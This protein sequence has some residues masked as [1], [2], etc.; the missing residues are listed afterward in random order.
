MWS[1]AALS[2]RQ[3]SDVKD[4]GG[5]EMTA[6]AMNRHKKNADV[7]AAG[8]GLLGCM[9]GSD[10]HGSGIR[11]T[12][13]A[14]EALAN[15][16][17]FATPEDDADA[18]AGDA[19]VASECS[20][21]ALFQL[22]TLSVRRDGSDGGR[23]WL[24]QLEEACKGGSSSGSITNGDESNDSLS[25]TVSK[26]MR[27]RESHPG[28]QTWALRLLWALSSIPKRTD[29][30]HAE[31]EKVEVEAQADDDADGFGRIDEGVVVA[32]G[33]VPALDATGELLDAVGAAVERHSNDAAV[34]STAL[35]L[36]LNLSAAAR[37]LDASS[38]KAA[39][40][41]TAN[42]IKAHPDSTEL[43][44]GGCAVICNLC[45][46]G[47]A[48]K[49]DDGDGAGG[50]D[51]AAAAVRSAFAAEGGVE[52]LVALLQRRSRDGK[53]DEG[54]LDLQAE[55]CAALTALCVD[56]AAS[57][58][59][60]AEAGG[61]RAL[62]GVYRDQI[63]R[64]VPEARILR[65]R[66]CETLASLAVSRAHVPTLNGSGIM[67]D[68]IKNALEEGS[69]SKP[70][71]A[72]ASASS[73]GAAANRRGSAKGVAVAIPLVMLN[74]LSANCSTEGE[75]AAKSATASTIVKFV[76]QN[77]STSAEAGAALSM[78]RALTATGGQDCV[79]VVVRSNVALD[80]I[81][82]AMETYGSDASLQEH[83]CALLSNIYCRSGG[84]LSHRDSSDIIS[85]GLEAEL[86]ARALRSHPCKEGVEERAC[87]A[88]RNFCAA[89]PL[90]VLS[91]DS[92]VP[93]LLS[94]AEEVARVLARTDSDGG[95]SGVS[96][97][98]RENAAG[99]LWALARVSLTICATVAS[100]SDSVVASISDSLHPFS[101]V[102]T[103][104]CDAVGALE[105]LSRI[106]DTHVDMGTAPRVDAVLECI[107]KY[108]GKED[109]VS[110]GVSILAALAVHTHQAKVN[111]IENELTIPRTI[112]CMYQY[113]D[114]ALI[115]GSA[116]AILASVAVDNYIKEQIV[117]EGGINLI[118]TVMSSYKSDEWVVEN[119]C[120]VLGNL[121]S[122][123]QSDIL[124]G[125]DIV[126]KIV[127]AVEAFPESE[128]VQERC[129]AALWNLSV[130]GAEFKF[131]IARLRGI[132]A[133]VKTM[134]AHIASEHVQEKGC[135][136]LW[137][138]AVSD[139][140][141][142]EIGQ[143][144]GIPAIINGAMAHI[145]NAQLQSEAIGALRTL[146]TNLENKER[147]REMDGVTAIVS[148]MWVHYGNSS[149]L[150]SA[151]S[152]LTNIAVNPVTNHVALTT[153]NELEA[154]VGGMRK[155]PQSEELQQQACILL[156]NYT[157]SAPN[158]E[159]MRANG[160]LFDLL[161]Q[162][163]ENHP[164]ACSERVIYIVDQ[165]F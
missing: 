32:K 15:A 122:G 136:T 7:Q 37:A 131:E 160:L 161:Q 156:R 50:Q 111:V 115:Q 39:A 114:S 128:G 20:L 29:D 36:L 6:T 148:A 13:G 76:L 124:L 147:I 93:V 59:K 117:N 105:V 135:V 103:L 52:S 121:I 44:T 116:C 54:R 70:A 149:L 41:A 154:I 5:V 96:P 165:L 71:S 67:V 100:L 140:N 77:Y 34:A 78:L 55:A 89:A 108:D 163:A 63:G 110:C 142:V 1:L 119:A 40:G 43:L 120:E 61:L 84:G 42:I 27:A 47:N 101:H 143:A 11:T 123:A 48:L 51:G 21:R 57:K 14:V 16:L 23:S 134:K 104:Q 98:V 64:N 9:A 109:L 130:K 2:D 85:L 132:H 8:C 88:L 127:S 28:V 56:S 4:C 112:G 35:A 113:P 137:S 133:I 17:R 38:A 74:L 152:A 102:E 82:S 69:V 125:N 144:G 72:S 87:L 10:R 86:V 92:V 155:F 162:A 159:L 126:Q 81:V 150:E 58:E 49:R 26:A 12:R 33:F 106:P 25:G 45:Y 66:A 94:A 90:S 158:L 65:Q 97:A 62:V 60:V 164:S 153:K 31:E 145:D 53:D 151:C 80:K 73:S 24:A 139:P 22:T 118:Q 138:L 79:D 95:L 19:A 68:L 157:F 30:V 91:H 3:K 129:M 99:F 75:G 141:Q 83:A 107:G 46:T 18:D 146:A